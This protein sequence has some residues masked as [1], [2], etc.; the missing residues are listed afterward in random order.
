MRK[1][2]NFRL[3]GAAARRGLL[4]SVALCLAA[5]AAMAADDCVTTDCHQTMGTAKWVHGPVGVGACTVCHK[6]VE[7]DDHAFTIPGK[8][9]DLC[10]AC[11]ETSRDLMLRR[12][13]HEPVAN[14]ECTACHD[15]H[16]SEYRFTLKGEAAGLCFQCHDSEEFM[17][18]FVH[19]PV[20]DG[21]CIVCHDP[22]ASDQPHQL[23]ASPP[24]LCLECHDDKE[25]DL[26]KATVHQ[27]VRDGCVG[28]HRP[29]ASR[30]EHMLDQKEPELC[31]G[32]HEDLSAVAEVSHPH[33]PVANGECSQC[34]EVH[35][36]DNP[37]LYVAPPERLC[38]TCHT[39][40]DEF[41]AAQKFKHGPVEEGDCSACHNPHGSGNYRILRQAFPEKF[42]IGY[43]EENYALCFDCHNRELALNVE[44][45][46]LTGFRDGKR[47]L[48]YLHVNKEIKGRSCKAC[49]QVHAS[50]QE[51]HIRTSV[52][53]G[54]IDW[55]LPV[56]F[57]KTD[58]GGSCQ[59]GCHKPK[60]YKRR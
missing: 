11:H 13:I 49:H 42:Y 28:C 14:G 20:A 31:V 25:E 16:Q 43:A 1:G 27:P 58:D 24:D 9:T 48:H 47:N 32:C 6:V 45:E 10:F 51:R 23:V 5:T 46:T 35:A 19:D 4:L 3:T 39:E 52:P 34:H 21:D 60:E 15:P 57:T 53:Y 8:Q 17:S 40:M 2:T 54:D 18:D 26:G 55:D 33:Q 30:A 29:H 37:R 38:F 41:V 36:S 56:N 44:T 22:H 12:N 7:G 50:S 59:V